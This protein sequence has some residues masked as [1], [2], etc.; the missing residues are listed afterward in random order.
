MAKITIKGPAITRSGTS[1]RT[2]R[3]YSITTQPAVLETD[4]IRT[5]FDLE[6]PDMKAERLVGSE[7]SWDPEG[8]L[9]IGRYGVEVARYWT[10][11]PMTAK[12]AA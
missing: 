2:G 1:N 6:L 3:D 10:L 4:N 8:D 12:K 11:V 9:K 5:P 7:W